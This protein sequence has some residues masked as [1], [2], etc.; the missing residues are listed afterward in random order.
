LLTAR[1]DSLAYA[2]EYKEQTRKSRSNRTILAAVAAAFLV[3]VA[4]WAAW[5]FQARNSNLER[6]GK[7]PRPPA[8]SPAVNSGEDQQKKQP[9]VDEYQA[10]SIELPAR[11]RDDPRAELPKFA[12]SR[13]KL[14]L[15]VRLPV[16]SPDGK[17]AV[18]ILDRSKKVLLTSQPSGRTESGTTSFK[19]PLDTSALSAGNYTLSVLEPGMDV[20]VDYGLVIR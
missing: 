13:G 10:A 3:A 20:W 2:E 18:R 4:L 15:T 11:W 6:A 5:H 16:G 12:L 19:L 1:R 14:L 9:E 8:P 7:V 17:Y